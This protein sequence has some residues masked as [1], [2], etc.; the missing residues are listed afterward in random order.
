MSDAP[1]KVL[2]AADAF[3]GET[4]APRSVIQRRPVATAEFRQ[5]W[6]DLP[7]AEAK[8]EYFARDDAFRALVDSL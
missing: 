4:P 8:K 5:W 6:N 2:R 3:T 7:A 1:V